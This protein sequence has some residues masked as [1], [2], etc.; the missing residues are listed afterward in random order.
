MYFK[1]WHIC[2][3]NGAFGYLVEQISHN[4]HVLQ[5]KIGY[6]C[7]FSRWILES[8]CLVPEKKKKPNPIWDFERDWIQHIS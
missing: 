1:I 4:Y 7:S 5:K 8:C 3:W 6:S 2:I